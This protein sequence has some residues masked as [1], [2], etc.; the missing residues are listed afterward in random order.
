MFFFADAIFGT[1]YLQ[2]FLNRQVE[3][4]PRTLPAPSPDVKAAQLVGW[5][6]GVERAMHNADRTTSLELA[7]SHSVGRNILL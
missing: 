4:E 3:I 6:A 7:K 1:S 5:D 2:Y